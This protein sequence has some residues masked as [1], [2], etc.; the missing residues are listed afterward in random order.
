MPVLQNLLINPTQCHIWSNSIRK[1]LI[2]ASFHSIKTGN[3][4]VSLSQLYT[5]EGEKKKSLGFSS[6][7]IFTN[8]HYYF[9]I[10]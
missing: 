9:Y 7:L 6:G 8:T 1:H 10:K 3:C 5:F 4:F 2:E